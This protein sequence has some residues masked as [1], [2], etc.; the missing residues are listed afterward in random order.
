MY[1]VLFLPVEQAG[2]VTEHQLQAIAPE[3]RW[4]RQ[5]ERFEKLLGSRK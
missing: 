2:L 1:N 5:R 4:D 3:L